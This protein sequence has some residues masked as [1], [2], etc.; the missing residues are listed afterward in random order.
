MVDLP[1]RTLVLTLECESSAIG[2]MYSNRGYATWVRR[3]LE[4]IAAS[5]AQTVLMA[6]F[7]KN[8]VAPNTSFQNLLKAIINTA[9]TEING[10]SGDYTLV[11]GV[12]T[13]FDRDSETGELTANCSES[14]RRD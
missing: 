11:D 13:W 8:V 12:S 1:T 2:I 3:P 10:A 5:V 14:H 6:K 9:A 7:Y 4:K